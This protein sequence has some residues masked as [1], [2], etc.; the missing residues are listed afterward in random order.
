MFANI[1][2]DARRITSI[3]TRASHR[4]IAL[5]TNLGFHAVLLYRVSHWLEQHHLRGLGL[6]V[7][8]WNA[9]FTGAQ[10][11]SRATI[12]KGL[13]VL[14]PHSMVVGG[15]AVVGDNCTLVQGNVIGQLRGNEG[16]PSIGDNFFAGA[17]AKILGKIRIGDNV[18][19]GANSVVMRS[20][21]TG[22]SLAVRTT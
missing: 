17:G 19:V 10:I 5:C 6:L 2:A 22:A 12:G 20:V 15:T 13:A 14:H 9:V 16:R 4:I 21:P 8:Y 7:S 11:S 18:R 3:E 1:R